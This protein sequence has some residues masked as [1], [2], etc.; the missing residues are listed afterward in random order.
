MITCKLMGG[1][2]NQ[3]FQIFTVISYSITHNIP[4]AFVYSDK[5]NIGR[6]R[7]TYWNN[8]L[9]SIKIYTNYNENAYV[10]N[11][12]SFMFSEI[13]KMPSVCLNGYF[14]SYKYFETNKET[15]AGICEIREHQTKEQ[16]NTKTI[17]MHFRIGDFKDLQEYHPLLPVNYYINALKYVSDNFDGDYDVLVFCEVEDK[18]TVQAIIDVMHIKYKVSFI[19]ENIP[20][21][22]QMV[23]MSCC[24]VNIIA[25][26][27]FSWWGAYLNNL[28]NHVVL[29]PNIWFGPRITHDISDL[30]PPEWQKIDC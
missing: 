20:D 30:F 13:P 26:S 11:E 7:P 27:T 19:D 25:N 6:E 8:M 24:D 16:I 29:Y 12:P 2:G 4:F 28:P 21:W 9:Q 3:L 10:Y 1:L 14:Q 15:I 17:S 22:R 23:I 18:H 5:V